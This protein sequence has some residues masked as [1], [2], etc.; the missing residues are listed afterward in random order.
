MKGEE[1]LSLVIKESQDPK[2]DRYNILFAIWIWGQ[3]DKI[4]QKNPSLLPMIK[5]FLPFTPYRNITI[6]QMIQLSFLQ[7]TFVVL[8]RIW[9]ILNPERKILQLVLLI[10]SN[11]QFFLIHY[12]VPF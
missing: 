1:L 8:T 4:K 9:V 11:S 6:M 3:F 2:Y 12:I 5:T 7:I 10:L